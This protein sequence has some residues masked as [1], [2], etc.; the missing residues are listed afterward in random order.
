M[1]DP[2][3]QESFQEPQFLKIKACDKAD[4]YSVSAWCLRV[5]EL[6]N[7]RPLK[8]KYKKGMLPISTH[9]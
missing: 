5:L 9:M 6:A 7:A 8:K 2:P 4:K 3:N 1:I